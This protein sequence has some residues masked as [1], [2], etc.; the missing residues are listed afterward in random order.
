M[1]M[2]FIKNIF[3]ASAVVVAMGALTACDYLDI[4]PEN[5]VPVQNV[6]FTDI[7]NMYQPVSGCYGAI[8]GCNMHWII[9][10]LTNMR[11][12]DIWSGRVDDQGDLVTMDKYVY[13]PS[14]WGVNEMWSQ[15]YNMI[16]H[17]NSA[18]QSLDSYAEH[19]TNDNDMKTYR[20]Y[21]GEVRIIRAL[22]YYRL[23][24]MFGDV[25][26]MDVNTQS[27]LRRSTRQV[28][29]EYIL[30]DLEYAMAN[31]P[32]V[33]PNEMAHVGAFSGYSAQAFAAKIYLQMENWQKV[34]ELTGDMITSGKFELYS[35]YYQLFKL[36]GRLCNESL[37]ESQVTDFG[38]G[39]G[40]YVGVDQFFNCCGPSISNPDT[41]T[42]SAGGWTFQGYWP[43]FVT[44]VE[45]RGET[46]RDVTSLLRGGTTTPSGD[47]V[48]MP[49]N[50]LNTNV[51]NGK[52][53]L[54]LEQFTT[55]R[56][57]YGVGNN[58][59]IMRYADVL[60]MNAEANVRLG[61]SGDDPFN[62]VRRRAKMPELSGVTLAQILDERRM[63]FCG[64]WGERYSD[65]LRT[66][67]AAKVLGSRG[68]TPALAY[69]PL[70]T[71]Q[72]DVTTE[73]KLEPF[74]T[75]DEALAQD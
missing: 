47:A 6:D 34:A 13:N 33:R 37:M 22:A 44:W 30:R 69:F 18:L 26:I 1:K 71:G 51:W 11:D 46:V 64:E 12:G 59:R 28:V 15:Y 14:W 24:Q 72:T 29:Y 8:R 42:K 66:G 23:T 67:E 21:C 73:L 53:Y 32:K 10:L 75:L 61:K 19:I 7:E 43:E 16:R 38:L 55:G 5:S 57:D 62:E 4:E 20:S 58:V 40:D 56:T 17:C 27:A 68:W 31:T 74:T 63:E 25:T 3:A 54:P 9:N 49:G 70:P 36:P 52:Y 65:L 50:S 48:A 60:L 2:K 45:G 41:E 39:S 35:D